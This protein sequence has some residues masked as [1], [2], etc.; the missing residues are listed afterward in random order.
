MGA[1]LTLD[2]L[3]I[4]YDREP[5]W[6]AARKFVEKMS[7]KDV[8]DA[9]R[10]VYGC[11]AKELVEE[12]GCS[13][14]R[15]EMVLGI[16]R[17]GFRAACPEVESLWEGRRDVVLLHMH[18]SRVLVTGERGCDLPDSCR[19][20]QRFYLSGAA[21]AAGFTTQQDYTVV[22]YYPDNGQRFC[23]HVHAKDAKAAEKSLWKRHS[24]VVV[25][26]VFRG[27]LQVVDGAPLMV[28]GSDE[29]AP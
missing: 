11:T 26:A 22:G 15:E 6:E 8:L 29:Q 9:G 13:P 2:A 7:D 18:S 16:L 21:H 25:V 17:D 3:E 19:A 10:E 20:V 5:D 14:V 24:G 28:G 12:I 4:P 23:D 1:D 27:I